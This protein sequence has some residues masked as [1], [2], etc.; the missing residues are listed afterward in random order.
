MPFF[1]KD[2]KFCSAV[3][4]LSKLLFLSMKYVSR[5]EVWWESGQHHSGGPPQQE[6]GGARPDSDPAEAA[7]RQSPRVHRRLQSGAGQQPQ[8]RPGAEPRAEAAHLGPGGAAGQGQPRDQPRGQHGEARHPLPGP[9]QQPSLSED[10]Q[11]P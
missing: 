7:V 2:N 8:P 6:P 11:H 1:C 9:G 5:V 3:G 4:H 10:G